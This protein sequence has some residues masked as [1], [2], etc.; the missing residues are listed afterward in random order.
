MCFM[1]LDMR[2]AGPSLAGQLPIFFTMFTQFLQKLYVDIPVYFS[3]SASKLSCI[4][5]GVASPYLVP[6]ATSA[7]SFSKCCLMCNCYLYS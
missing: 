7:Q 6:L 3:G 4:D 5:Q 1:C 2:V